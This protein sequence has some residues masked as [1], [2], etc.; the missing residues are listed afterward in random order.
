MREILAWLNEALAQKDLVTGMTYYRAKDGTISATDGRLTA[1][2]PWPFDGDF[3]APG[4]EFEK[5]LKRMPETPTLTVSDGMIKL[6]SGKFNGSIRTLPL[7]EW[8]HPGIEGADNWMPIPKGLLDALGV[9]RPFISD[10]AKHGWALC[11][12][13][14]NGWAYSTNNVAMAGVRCPDLG[15][16]MALLPVWAVDF[17]LSRADGVTHWAW[18]HN[19]VAFGWDSGAWMRAQLVVGQF[20]ERAAALVRDSIKE[21]P[22]QVI[23]PDFREAFQQ[24]AE[25]AEDTISI[26]ADRIESTFGKAA[27][28]SIAECRTPQEA[29]CS[30]WGAKYLTPVLQVAKSWSPDAWPKPAPFKGD[31]VSGYVV[32][33][34]M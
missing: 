2:H 26:Y 34:R 1:S 29:D 11:V 19:Y 20:P 22:T 30:I 27:V 10:N 6:R 8:D 23:T 12:A 18:T 31:G 33:R 32:G 13:L 9:L 15:K 16:I 14:E 5:I 17:L 21:K 4:N 7:T 28:V 24:I 25:L 3:L